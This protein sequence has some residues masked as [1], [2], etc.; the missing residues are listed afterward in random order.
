MTLVTEF[1][2]K[3]IINYSTFK[4]SNYIL[5]ISVIT[6]V[7]LLI[8][9]ACSL[10]NDTQ[11]DNSNDSNHENE[12]V[13][14][15]YVE[16][17]SEVASAHVVKT[18]IE[19][20]L[21]YQTELL[22]VSTIAMWEAVA[23]GDQDAMVAAWMPSLHK[24]YY[25]EHKEN[26]ENLGPNLD[27]AVMGLAVPD[28]LPIESIEELNQY[29]EELNKK[30]IGID[31][32]AG[33]MTK[34]NQVID[35]YRLDDFVLVSGSD[36]TMTQTLKNAIEEK[37]WIVVTGWNPHWKFA[38]W[39]LKYLKDTKG[40]YGEKEHISTIVR[41]GLEQ[42]KPEV[43]RFLDQFYWSANDMEKVMLWTE[44]DNN[45]EAAAEQWVKENKDIVDSWLN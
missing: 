15:V 36:S 31:P 18:V 4:A 39:D 42:D 41:K 9:S 21:G 28:Y 44:K 14:I 43:Y 13:K 23:S 40:I 20:R 27:G 32:G 25:E 12:I 45:P 5:A 3:T 33:V 29:T 10:E 26:V 38:R 30:I 7:I 22:P 35:E 24:A 1:R 6:L 11:N 8:L 37:R 19:D 16:W 17:A 34:T 2:G